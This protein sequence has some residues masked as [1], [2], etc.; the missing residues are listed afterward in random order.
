MLS[1]NEKRPHFTEKPFQYRGRF[2]PSPSGF[3][4][5]GSL[6]AALA[7][8]LD[9]KSFNNSNHT[10]GKWLLRIEDIDPPREQ[11]GASSA[12]LASLMHSV[13][14]GMKQNFTKVNSSIT[15]AIF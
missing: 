2:A 10:Q 6:I 5:F 4:H 7:S 12:I 14:N 8:F 9:A 3:L 1:P 11:A 15:I 13:Y